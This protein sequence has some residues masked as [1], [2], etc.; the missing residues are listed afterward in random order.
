MATMAHLAPRDLRGKPKA[1][2]G[3]SLR[4]LCSSSLSRT[5]TLAGTNLSPVV[6]FNFSLANSQ[7]W[8]DGCSMICSKYVHQKQHWSTKADGF[9]HIVQQTSQTSLAR[10]ARNSGRAKDLCNPAR[11]I[12]QHHLAWSFHVLPI[13]PNLDVWRNICSKWK[14][15]PW[16]TI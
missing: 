9:L 16:N 5:S 7:F 2:T 14:G 8:E 1:S 4:N 10:L 12:V 11:I 15:T 13:D 3:T 6:I